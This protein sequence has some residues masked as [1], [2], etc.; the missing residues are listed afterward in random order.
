M[1]PGHRT[2]LRV[3]A[4]HSEAAASELAQQEGPGSIAEVIGARF[5]AHTSPNLTHAEIDAMLQ[6]AAADLDREAASEKRRRVDP[7]KKAPLTHSD[8]AALDGAEGVPV[9]YRRDR[10]TVVTGDGPSPA[11][12]YIDHRVVPGPP[13]PGYLPR[14]IDGAVHHGLPQCWITEAGRV[15]RRS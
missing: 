10:L 12:V 6:T 8:L 3:P 5:G 15:A 1:L 14:I 13:R 7:G 9:R 2:K 4:H 11:W